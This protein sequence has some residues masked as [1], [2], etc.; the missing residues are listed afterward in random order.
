MD[1]Q[2]LDCQWKDRK[3]NEAAS[4]IVDVDVRSLKRRVTGRVN[5]GRNERPLRQA[6]NPSSTKPFQDARAPALQRTR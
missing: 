6:G 3:L 2:G 1:L 4:D 5:T